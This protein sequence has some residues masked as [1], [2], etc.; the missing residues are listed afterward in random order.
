[1]VTTRQKSWLERV[2]VT[3]VTN[4]APPWGSAATDTPRVPVMT[5][6]LPAGQSVAPDFHS[7]TDCAP[8]G[9]KSVLSPLKSGVS[10]TPVVEGSIPAASETQN[11]PADGLVTPVMFFDR[12]TTAVLLSTRP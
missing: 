6:S 12:V 1:E 11:M 10:T 7:T 9:L 3:W 5:S 2:I 8:G 4:V